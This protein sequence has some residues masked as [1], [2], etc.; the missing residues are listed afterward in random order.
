LQARLTITLVAGEVINITATTTPAPC[1]QRH[2]HQFFFLPKMPDSNSTLVVFTLAPLTSM[3]T[4][5]LYLTIGIIMIEFLP[6]S[7]LIVSTI[8]SLI[9]L[10]GYVYT[11]MGLTFLIGYHVYMLFTYLIHYNIK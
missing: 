5:C 9:V 11:T 10:T 2:C 8:A 6:F 1:H 4:N 3:L 7:L